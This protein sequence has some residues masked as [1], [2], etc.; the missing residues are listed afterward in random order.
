MSAERAE[1]CTHER[2]EQEVEATDGWCPLCLRERLASSQAEVARLTSELE[3]MRAAHPESDCYASYPQ[4]RQRAAA[5]SAELE[6]ETA[7]RQRVMHERAALESE[8]DHWHELWEQAF[9][10]NAE[11]QQRAA[12]AEAT[13]KSAMDAGF[14]EWLESDVAQ[15]LR[16]AKERAAALE[17]IIHEHQCGVHTTWCGIHRRYHGG[18]CDEITRAAPRPEGA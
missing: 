11:H 4:L 14:K 3:A 15:T 7:F 2:W 17:R 18:I 6:Q 10:A 1:V 5:L 8:R 13:L 12:A 9:N 16:M